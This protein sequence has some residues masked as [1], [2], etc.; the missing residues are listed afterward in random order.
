METSLR[1]ISGA[2]EEG[3][4][5]EAAALVKKAVI[6]GVPV[7]EILSG[8]LIPGMRALGARFKDGQAFLPE[9]FISARAMNL[10]LA[11]LRPYLAGQEGGRGTVVL[12]TVKDDL[13]DIG[14][15]LVGMLLDCNGYAV[16]DLGVDVEAEAFVE[17]VRR[18]RPD[19]L[20]LSALLTTTAAELRRVI[21]ALEKA[22]LRDAVKVMV[23]GA[24]ISPEYAEEIGAD[25]YADDC[26]G[27]VEEA[28][29]ITQP[30]W[31]TEPG[32]LTGETKGAR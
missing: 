21:E 14:K 30:G 18:R 26:V 20:A 6:A 10:G 32:R 19:I 28:D 13:H 9:I 29:R 25:G 8:G 12:G 17:A 5:Q 16:V 15:N 24:C 2:V 3:D 1:A 23:G 27:A 7:N 22:G 11:E 31:S 4:A